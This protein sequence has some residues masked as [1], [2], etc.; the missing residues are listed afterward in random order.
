MSANKNGLSFKRDKTVAKVIGSPKIKQEYY[1]MNDNC[2]A[3]FKI[4][5][6]L[7]LK[8]G[9]QFLADLRRQGGVL[10]HGQLQQFQKQSYL[11]MVA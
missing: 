10:I 4:F 6:K 11:R 3:R 1:A 2:I 9:K 7:Y 5:S 8:H